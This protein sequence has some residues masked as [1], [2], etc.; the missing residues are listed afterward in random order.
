MGKRSIQL[1]Q[2]VVPVPLAILVDEA[3]RLFCQ[4]DAASQDHANFRRRTGK[5]L[6]DGVPLCG[7]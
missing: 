2:P 4:A 7:S 6:Y 1:D 3:A 5:D